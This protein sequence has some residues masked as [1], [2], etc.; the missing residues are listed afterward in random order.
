MSF[1]RFAVLFAAFLSLSVMGACSSKPGAS[2]ASSPDV[3][4][5]VD[6]REIRKD[7]VEKSYR[8][9]ADP[10]ATM[11]EEETLTAKLSVLN[12]MI[13][14]DLLLAKAKTLNIEASGAEIETAFAER[15]KGMSEDAFQK[16]L[17]QRGLTTTDIKEDLRKELTT[18]K[19]I[20]REIGARVNVSEQQ[21]VDYFNA[22]RGRFNL[23]EPATHLAQI[24]ITP[25][26]EEQI[27]NRQN[28]DAAT[29]AAATAKV[30]MILERIRT[31]AQFNELAMDYSEDAQTAPQGGD[32][33]LVPA[34]QL[35]QANPALR[36]AVAKAQPGSVSQV[37]LGG[38]YSLVLVVAK[39]AAGQRD[40]STPGVR[41]NITTV[42]KDRQQQ[43]VQGAYLTELRNGAQVVNHLAKQILTQHAPVAAPASAAPTAPAGKK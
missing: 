33:G 1:R 3:W 19:V 14:Q 15:K 28:D 21:V 20:E 31:G 5:T 39:E 23:A 26:R 17:T 16:E 32:L 36:D 25:V 6:G 11:S 2:T 24:I 41:D 43:L 29:P 34:S 12:E 30:R 40:L 35:A 10:A 9:V 38:G 18:Q 27:N 22:N 42:L 7:A 13:A 37:T 4:A 8:R